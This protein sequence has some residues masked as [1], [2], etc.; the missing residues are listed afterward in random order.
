MPWRGSD[1]SVHPVHV[2]DLVKGL[3]ACLLAFPRVVGRTY[4]LA[5]P[6][7]MPISRVI[8][9]LAGA[10]GVRPP[11][12]L[13]RGPTVLAAKIADRI[14]ATT[15]VPLPITTRRLAFFLHANAFDLERERQDFGYAPDI[16]LEQ[17][18]Q[19]TIAWCKGQ[20]LLDG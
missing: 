19:G 13:P 14:S 7:P 15:G 10:L 9:V 3:E 6:E 17:G 8:P 2:D 12:H 5:G 18:M 4:H 16:H 11:P 1:V 20:G